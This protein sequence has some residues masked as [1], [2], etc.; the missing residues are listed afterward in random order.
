MKFPFFKRTPSEPEKTKSYQHLAA[1]E[2]SLVAEELYQLS[3]LGIEAPNQL[4]VSP[5]SKKSQEFTNTIQTLAAKLSD[6]FDQS[7]NIGQIKEELRASITAYGSWQSQEV[8]R[9][10][11]DLLTSLEK[12]VESVGETLQQTS[13]VSDDIVGVQ[14]GLRRAQSASSI[15]EM[16]TALVEETSK[17]QGV[18][19]KSAQVQQALR[20]EFEESVKILERQLE[21][22]E[23][24]GR[25]DHL[26][27]VA[28]R[29]AFEQKIESAF[30]E[31]H[32]G[33]K[34]WS[35]AITDLNKFKAINDTMGH[36]AG[37]ACLKAFAAE[38]KSVFTGLAF[39]ARLGGDEFAVLFPGSPTELEQ[40]LKKVQIGLVRKPVRVNPKDAHETVT[41]ACSFGVSKMVPGDDAATLYNRAD[42]AMYAMKKA[43]GGL[44]RSAA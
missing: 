24:N 39:F 12:V 14:S 30:S 29:A 1:S 21:H 4:L 38:L 26:T 23:E 15:E 35:L 22:A 6:A 36:A 43:T 16:R 20:K 32:K 3:L 34:P 17:L 44:G 9:L 11:D 5:G 2:T 19:A 40:N 7:K 25:T 13:A 37:D 42:E 18:V 28:N 41:L 8:D 33:G 27:R 10:V 31:F